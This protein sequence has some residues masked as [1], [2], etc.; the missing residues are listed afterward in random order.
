VSPVDLE[1][2]LANVVASVVLVGV[3]AAIIYWRNKSTLSVGKSYLRG[4]LYLGWLFMR[5]VA[6]FLEP[7]PEAN[8]GEA[9]VGKHVDEPAAVRCQEK[10][11]RCE[12]VLYS[13]VVI[14][15]SL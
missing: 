2:L 4:L 12:Q 7:L 14:A 11:S 9:T 6:L 15:C 3:P 8:T 1:E 13:H 10:P 5:T